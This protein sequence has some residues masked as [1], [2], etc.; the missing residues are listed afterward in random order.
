M[1]QGHEA[2][3]VHARLGRAAGEVAEGRAQVDVLRQLAELVRPVGHAGARDDSG[4]RMSVSNAVILPGSSRW[5]PMWKPL[6]EL[7]TM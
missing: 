2:V 6:S 3:T 4:T 5:S 1:E 7:N